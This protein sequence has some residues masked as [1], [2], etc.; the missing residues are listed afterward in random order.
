MSA[1]GD[2]RQLGRLGELVGE[3]G[4]CG[5]RECESESVSVVCASERVSVVYASERVSVVYASERVSVVYAS[6]RVSQSVRFVRV[7]E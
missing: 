2:R 7:R 3:R 4:V 6:E 5:V 1:S